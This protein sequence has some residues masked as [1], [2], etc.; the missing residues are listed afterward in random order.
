MPEW[1]GFASRIVRLSG[2]ALS[3]TDD[4]VVPA[5]EHGERITGTETHRKISCWIESQTDQEFAVQWEAPRYDISFL[6]ELYMDGKFIDRELLD[7]NHTKGNPPGWCVAFEGFR[8]EDE[9]VKPFVFSDI[10]FDPNAPYNDY[11]P[12]IGS[13]QLR[14]YHILLKLEDKRNI[15]IV[16]GPT[17]RSRPSSGSLGEEK[18]RL[19]THRVSTRSTRK[20]IKRPK[21][22]KQDIIWTFKY[23]PID[24]DAEPEPFIVFEFK[25]RSQAFLQ[26]KGLVKSQ[27]NISKATGSKGSRKKQRTKDVQ[28][29]SSC[30]SQSLITSN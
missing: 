25:Y 16:T 12:E 6:V 20:P 19:V 26:A 10:Q 4:D 14:F 11:S 15:D 9:T 23:L 22:I 29:Q 2:A 1:R 17:P 30:I 18:S 27:E 13:I 5:E 28:H 8:Q 3:G 7:K 21:T 24:D